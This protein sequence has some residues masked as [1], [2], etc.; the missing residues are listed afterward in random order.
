MLRFPRRRAARP[1]V[2]LFALTLGIAAGVTLPAPR[3]AAAQIAGQGVITRRI[4]PAPAGADALR[5]SVLG[6]GTGGRFEARLLAPGEDGVL[7]GYFAAPPVTLDFKGWKTLTFPFNGFVFHSD[8]NP[9]T[10]T[11]GMGSAA[12]LPNASAVAFSLVAV[13]SRVSLDALGWTTAAALPTDPLLGLI[14]NFETPATGANA[15]QVGGDWEQR[16]TVSIGQTKVAKGQKAGA[17]ALQFVVRSVGRNE[18]DLNEPA[19]LA[20]LKRTPALPYVVYVRPPFE[21]ITPDSAPS[22]KEITPAPKVS[23][24]ATPGEVEPT[25]FAVYSALPIKGATVTLRGPLVAANK[26]TLP[27]SA[28]DIRVVRVG[29][30]G[31][32]GVPPQLLMKDDRQPLTGPLPRVRLT[33]DCI[34]DIAAATTRQF[35]VTVR[36]GQN[37]APGL[38]TGKLVFAA[39]GVK[40][41]AVTLSVEVLPL[42]LRTAHYQYG[43]DLPTV[44]GEAGEGELTVSPELFRAELNNL[45]DH[46][47]KIVALHDKPGPSLEAALR[48]YADARVS[49]AGPVIIAAP[50]HTAS[51]I[52]SVEG[53]RTS[54]SL[55]TGFGLYYNLPADATS[56]DAAKKFA[57]TLR[58]ADRNA[59][60]VS[61]IPSA[62]AYADLSGAVGDML[63][64]VYSLSS[65]Y[66]QKVLADGKRTT[67]N[68]DWWAWNVGQASPLRNRLLAGFLLYKT[69]NG[70]YGA[71]PGPYLAATPTALA[72]FNDPAVPSTAA[73]VTVPATAATSAAPSGPDNPASHPAVYAVEGGVLDT[74]QWEAVREGVDDVRYLDILK[75]YSRELKD[76]K[77]R[78]DATDAADALIAAVLRKPFLTLA[79]GEQQATRRTV[80]LQALKL[81]AIL[82]KASPKG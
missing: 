46:G 28:V 58:E 9:T 2:T 5:V 36:V 68:H 74:V 41:T 43:V 32:T 14:D 45:R 71:I 16:R 69:G 57:E 70:L 61:L 33:G 18:G 65:D 55:P 54:L 66:A 48:A 63:A 56:P 53:L 17:T 19:L 82:K 50:V 44:L 76:L 64:P 30:E 20:R 22:A 42:P 47:V 37:Q 6:D 31:E 80:A 52:A 62:A 60:I 11:D 39:A 67:G 23:L 78:K 81:Q 27:Q 35:W 49:A 72:P 10:H 4:S 29:Q 73:T 8:S 24:F 38:Y 1:A 77:L 7:S 21:T 25:S 3:P 26:A 79:P 59:L 75:T 40:P 13:S 51:E 15:W 34:T 12:G